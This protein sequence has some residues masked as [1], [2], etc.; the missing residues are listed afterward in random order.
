M[1]KRLQIRNFRGF[2]A[3]KIDQL[4]SINLIAGKNNSGKTSL[5]EAVFLLSGGGDASL[6][7]NVNIIRGLELDSRVSPVMIG[8]LW[9]QLFSDLDMER[10]IEIEGE[11]TTHGQFTLKITSGR[12]ATPE[13]ALDLI[14][15]TSVPD[16]FSERPLTFQYIDPS[17][18]RVESQ[19]RVKG[20]EFEINQPTTNA[21]FIAAILLSRGRN[22]YEDATRLGQLRRKKQGSL[23]LEALQVIDP[24]LQS[25]E[26]N[27]SSGT[28]MIWGDIGLSELVPLPAMGE[29]MTQLARIVLAI[30]FIPDGV[31]LVD[32][33]ENGIHHS[34]LP[35]VWRAI[36]EAAKQFRTQVFA[37]THSLECVMAAHESLSADRFRLHRLEIAD[38]K[39]RC[40]TYEPDAIAA[41]I[42]HNLEVR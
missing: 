30:A 7:K 9:K 38:R 15:E 22:I 27:S 8:P 4:S 13:T 24:K 33:V 16:H 36:D 5:L 37:T 40:V 18:K 11:H 34:V 35:D 19:I 2:N 42:R 3:L 12:Q 1:L 21:P 23:L 28:S 39:S 41:A 29:G 6:A 20:Q 14:E 25:I 10:A 31:V 32:E 26:E 17:G